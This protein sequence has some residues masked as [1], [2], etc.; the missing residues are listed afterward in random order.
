MIPYRLRRYRAPDQEPRKF[1]SSAYTS[2]LHNQNLKLLAKTLE[3]HGQD[4]NRTPWL[5]TGIGVIAVRNTGPKWDFSSVYIADDKMSYRTGLHFARHDVTVHEDK[6]FKGRTRIY[7]TAQRTIQLFTTSDAA[8]SMSYPTINEDPVAASDMIEE[9]L[10]APHE[11]EIASPESINDIFPHRHFALRY[12]VGV[13][14]TA[15]S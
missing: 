11:L 13:K 15:A 14:A 12:W 9:M 6:G 7:P 5:T 10:T 8:W 1:D 4:S 2:Y 3:M